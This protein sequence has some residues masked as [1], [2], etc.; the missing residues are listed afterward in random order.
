MIASHKQCLGNSRF[1]NCISNVAFRKY[2]LGNSDS[3]TVPRKLVFRKWRFENSISK[4]VSRKLCLGKLR[5]GPC[6]PESVSRKMTFS[7]CDFDVAIAT[8]FRHFPKG[9]SPLCNFR[10]RGLAPFVIF[11][12]LMD[13]RCPWRRA[14]EAIK[15]S[16]FLRVFTTLRNWSVV[17]A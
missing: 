1:G 10:R 6:V 11:A 7:N 17:K 9:L 15:A 5:F 2:Q 14:S 12:S 13:R 4:A 8:T 3:E 16:S